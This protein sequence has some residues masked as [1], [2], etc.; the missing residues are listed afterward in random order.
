MNWTLYSVL[1]VFNLSYA[2]SLCGEEEFSLVE[3]QCLKKHEDSL[4]PQLIPLSGVKAGD[5]YFYK[6]NKGRL[7]KIYIHQANANKNECTL[8]F[9]F[10]TYGK[11]DFT[12]SASFKITN[13]LGVWDQKSINLDS[14][15]IGRDIILSSKQGVLGADGIFNTDGS[16]KEKY[17]CYLETNRSGIILAGTINKGLSRKNLLLYI[18]SIFLIGFAAFNIAKLIFDD[19]EQYK[20]SE[21]I[22]D[23]KTDVISSKDGLILKYSTPFFRR[24]LNPIVNGLKNKKGI[25]Q[26]YKKVLATAGIS[27]LITSVDFYSFKLFSIITFPVLYLAMREGFEASWPLTLTPLMGVLGYIYPD[28][29]IKSK[30]DKRKSEIVMQLPFIVDML[31]LS[32]EAGLDFVAALTRI[33]KKAP[34]SAL[35]DEFEIVVKEIQLGSSRAQALKQLAWRGDTLE[36]TSFCATL[37]A[38]DSV[39]ASIGPILKSLSGEIRMKRS[40]L[41]EKKGA[42]AATKLLL[43]TFVFILPAIVLIIFSP[44]ALELIN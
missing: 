16:N 44:M 2:D 18:A 31:A 40:G 34:P 22:E 24:Y 6:T 39:G 9:D 7:G 1:L 15:G 12:R 37:I 25:Q 30:A 19:E 32:V 35:L 10:E 33:L 23:I 29:W 38:A 27:R 13:Y 41:I 5:I 36:L 21:N 14:D 20:N 42:A 8:H 28:I 11:V 43:P 4:Q 17:D 26:K 3:K